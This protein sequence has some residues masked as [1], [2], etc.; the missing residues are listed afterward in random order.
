MDIWQTDKLILFLI[1][2]IP[3]F[4]S[5]KIYDLL[6]PGQQ[7]DFS[8][9][10]VEVVGYSA[11]NYAALSWLIIWLYSGNFYQEKRVWFIVSVVFIVL[12]VPAVWP[13][14]FTRLWKWRPIARYI[15]HPIKKPWDYIFG[16]REPY[17]VIVHLKDGRK[18]GGKFGEESFA[19]SF[20][21][22]EQIYMEEVWEL[23]EEGKFK[24][25][26]ERSAGIIVLA[27]EISSIELF[28]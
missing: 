9:S 5:L 15:V 17:W 27:D 19:S 22:E 14:L 16:K 28:K 23:D 21:A 11:L 2:F 4:V 26:I 24:I 10:L 13:V 18:I 20:P 25:P 8:K 7:R 3:G 12:I 6:I 1:F